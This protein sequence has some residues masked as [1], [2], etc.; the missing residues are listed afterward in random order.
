MLRDEIHHCLPRHSLPIDTSGLVYDKDYEEN[1]SQ[2]IVCRSALS[3]V[4][5]SFR[6]FNRKR[7]SSIPIR[8]LI[9]LIFALCI[10]P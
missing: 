10:Q 1:V 4:L 6:V 5:L 3:H 9:I 7:Y 2:Y 8:Q